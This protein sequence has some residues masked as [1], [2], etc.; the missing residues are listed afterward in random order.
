M[1]LRQRK[2]S[3]AVCLLSLYSAQ[4]AQSAIVDVFIATGQSNAWWG[5]NP[6]DSGYLF[7]HG[8]QDTLIASGQ[9]SNPT[10]VIQGEPGQSIAGWF[11]GL[12]GVIGPRW[13]YDK[14]FFDSTP[15]D[16]P[17]VG[18]LEAQINAIFAAGD[19]PRFRGLF[20]F[21]GESDIGDG[22][23]LYTTRWNGLLDTLDVD[24]TAAGVS[25]MDY[26]FVMNTV[27]DLGPLE[28]DNMN[29]ILADITDADSRGVLFDT[30]VAPYRTDFNDVHGYDHYAVGQ[31]NAQLFINSFV[32]VPEPSSAV[33][34]GLGSLALTMRRRR[35]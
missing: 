35:A 12:G 21:Q 7:G 31:A 17:G 29:A 14:Q 20:W 24:L 9:F 3:L 6:D 10:V 18:S 13:I 11:D 16:A 33:L 1:K 32:A 28:N 26:N 23:F 34:T 19:T 30:Q 4:F 8:V 22:E 2:S 5:D 15:L 25:S 27:G